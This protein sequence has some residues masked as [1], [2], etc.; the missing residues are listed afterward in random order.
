MSLVQDVGMSFF[1]LNSPS[2]SYDY[3]D[4]AMRYLTR[5][6]IEKVGF[7]QIR[8]EQNLVYYFSQVNSWICLNWKGEGF[9]TRCAVDKLPQ[10]LDECHKLLHKYVPYFI[11][12]KQG[13]LWLNSQVSKSIFPS[14]TSYDND[15]AENIGMKLLDG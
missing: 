8:E 14:T 15:Y 6:L 11:H 10:V 13:R 2:N 12:S 7:D 3:H 1:Y 9:K 4:V 5:T